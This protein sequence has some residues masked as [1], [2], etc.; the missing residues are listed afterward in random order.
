MPETPLALEARSVTKAFGRIVALDNVSFTLQRGEIHALVGHNG[1]GK[2]TLV[3]TLA[4]VVS[5]D[6]ER[7]RKAAPTM[8]EPP[9]APSTGTPM[10]ITARPTPLLTPPGRKI[11]GGKWI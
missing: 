2:S 5:P 1:A 7:Q 11:L 3:K 4:G 8:R 10:A 6:Q 9:P